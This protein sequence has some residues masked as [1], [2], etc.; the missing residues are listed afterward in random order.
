MNSNPYTYL[1]RIPLNLTSDAQPGRGLV[2][3]TVRTMHLPAVLG[4][5]TSAMGSGKRLRSNRQVDH[6]P[7]LQSFT[8]TGLVPFP[9][10]LDGDYLGMAEKL[11]IAY[12]PHALAL[13]APPSR[14]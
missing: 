8:V 2:A 1:G 3:V 6:R 9:Y 10:Q 4:L 11:D 7:D 14:G 5:L 12:E 13:V